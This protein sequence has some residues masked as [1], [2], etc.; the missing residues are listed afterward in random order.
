M[1]D[2]EKLEWVLDHFF[3]SFV[4]EIKQSLFFNHAINFDVGCLGERINFVLHGTQGTPSNGGGAFDSTDS[5]E[6][7]A[8]SYMQ[9]GECLD[10]G[11]KVNFY[12]DTCICGSQNIKKKND[13]RFG[14]STTAHFKYLGEIPFYLLT[15]LRPLNKDINNPEFELTVYKI[16]ADNKFFNDLLAQQNVMKSKGKNFM[17][18]S[19]MFYGSS[20]T[21]LLSLKITLGDIIDYDYISQEP[22][23]INTVPADIF[24]EKQLK[25]LRD[26][27]VLPDNSGELLVEKVIPVIGLGK[28]TGGKKRGTT[29]RHSS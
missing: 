7:K 22:R 11:R 23:L 9:P 10:C 25:L 12:K 4:E 19:W 18:K 20:P 3:K 17:P 13:T 14:I 5:S 24:N 28:F 21:E 6:S 8:V 29:S 16:Q 15:K 27:N 2:K 1:F 26:N